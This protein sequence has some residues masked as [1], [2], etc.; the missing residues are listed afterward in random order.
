MSKSRF[1]MT[2]KGFTL[3]ELMVVIIIIGILIAIAIPVYKDISA[4]SR[5]RA[6]AANIRIIEG[7]IQAY[8]AG[9]TGEYSNLTLNAD[10]TIG[11]TGVTAGNLV[12]EY[13]TAMPK[14]PYD[15]TKSYTKAANGKVVPQS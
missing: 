2:E 7:S 14:Y 13:L 9:N 10:G 4:S 12:P 15:D 5:D 3:V 8:L 1:I 6:N 11:G